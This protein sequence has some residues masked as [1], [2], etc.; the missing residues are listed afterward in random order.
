MSNKRLGKHVLGLADGP[1]KKGKERSIAG[2][3]KVCIILESTLLPDRS[4]VR[5]CY[6]LRKLQLCGVIHW[7]NSY[8]ESAVRYQT[9][10]LCLG[11][12]SARSVCS[13]LSWVKLDK[14]E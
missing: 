3:V 7:P 6:S 11:P 5:L 13:V 10:N 9:K 4:V 2:S 1:T 8:V 14:T 12:L